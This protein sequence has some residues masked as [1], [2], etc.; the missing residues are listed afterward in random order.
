MMERKAGRI[1]N[2]GSIA[3]LW[4]NNAGVIYATAKAAVHHYTRCLAKQMRPFD[5]LV[6]A[7]APG[8]IVT[9]RIS[10]SRKMD[11]SMMLESGTQERYG[12]PIEIARAVKFLV[13]GANTYITGQV[14]RVDGGLQAWPA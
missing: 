9:N 3:G 10:A 14:L 11:E 13:S 1:V 6:N 7:I 5:V 2:F 8:L 12:R 4:G